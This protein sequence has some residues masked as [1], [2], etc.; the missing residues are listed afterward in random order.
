MEDRIN[1]LVRGL[2]G[3]HIRVDPW[4]PRDG[5]LLDDKADEFV[6]EVLSNMGGEILD[7]RINLQPLNDSW[8]SKR[9]KR[10]LLK[11]PKLGIP[12]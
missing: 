3:G 9:W 2:K 7:P 4:R 6:A 5:N 1:N 12:S 8:E 11:L 10:S